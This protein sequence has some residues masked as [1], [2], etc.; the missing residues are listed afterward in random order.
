M[1]ISALQSWEREFRRAGKADKYIMLRDHLRKLDLPDNP[2]LLMEG[3]IRFVQ[4][5][6]AYLVIDKQPLA[7]FLAM[8]RYDP[9]GAVDAKY[10]LTF[11]LY[12]KAYARILV[13]DTIGM[14]L[15]DLYGHPWDDYRVCG[16]YSMCIS[17]IDDKG[18]NSEELDQFE[19]E[20]TDDLLFDYSEDELYF[21]FDDMTVEGSLVVRLQDRDGLDDE[22]TE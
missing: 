3:T 4:A 19:Q 20:V 5:C 10:A 21:W 8:Q 9:A 11:D 18:L 13:S 7:G 2:K 14:D 1:G 6:V 17:R 12:G 16:Y 15:A 22:D